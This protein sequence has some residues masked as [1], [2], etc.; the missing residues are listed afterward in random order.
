MSQ[1]RIAEVGGDDVTYRRIST[2]RMDDVE[3]SVMRD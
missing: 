2:L 3:P 1:G